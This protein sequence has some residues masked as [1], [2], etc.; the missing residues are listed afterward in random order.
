L[1]I[2]L[3]ETITTVKSDLP[4]LYNLP[5]GVLP[6]MPLYR[7]ARGLPHIRRQGLLRVV[8]TAL[9][10][11]VPPTTTAACLNTCR[12]KLVRKST[13]QITAFASSSQAPLF[14]NTHLNA[15]TPRL[16]RRPLDKALPSLI[17]PRNMLSSSRD[18][19]VSI[20][21]D[22]GGFYFELSI[23]IL[24]FLNCFHPGLTDREFSSVSE[25]ETPSSLQSLLK[26]P[27]R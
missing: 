4:Y 12:P 9:P 11:P 10:S 7:G 19:F 3:L 13:L 8:T 6:L 1:E 26:G 23:S 2:L 25:T 14:P 5:F 17:Y 21:P 15:P 18:T 22:V 24:E 27:G 16:G 20:S